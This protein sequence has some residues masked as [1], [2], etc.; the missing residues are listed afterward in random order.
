MFLGIFFET[1]LLVFLFPWW[2]LWFIHLSVKSHIIFVLIVSESNLIFVVL[3]S[4]LLFY[5]QFFLILPFFHL[6]NGL[7]VFSLTLFP[8]EF[9]HFQSLDFLFFFLL[10]WYPL[11]QSC[12]PRVIFHILIWVP[13]FLFEEFL[14]PLNFFASLHQFPTLYFRWWF[15]NYH[16]EI[17]Y[18][19]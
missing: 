15:Y 3:S 19:F 13:L 2:C 1:F 16:Q 11:I 10:V 14:F 7:F 5:S 6:P 17:E 18:L 12:I 9:F 4:N 8:L